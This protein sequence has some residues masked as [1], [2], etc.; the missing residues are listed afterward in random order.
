MRIWAFLVGLSLLASPSLA[1][2]PVVTVGPKFGNGALE[3]CQIT[4]DVRFR[5]TGCDQGRWVQAAGS[6]TIYDFAD[7]GV[8]L[9]LKL[10]LLSLAN[11]DA[12]A[13][14][15]ATAYFINGYSTNSVDTIST[16]ESETPGY[17]L[18]MFRGG[19]QTLN[20]IAGIGN[21]GLTIG[22]TRGDG[23]IA[24]EFHVPIHDQ[25]SAQWDECLSALLASSP[26][27]S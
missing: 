26:P 19:E 1:Q 18:V 15:P 6:F 10:G 5:D 3:G 16:L 7:R 25:Q 27:Q 17:A 23:R 4:F 24:Q 9:M 21:V 11:P 2:E 8:G 14:K 13:V 22:Y 12:P 20:A